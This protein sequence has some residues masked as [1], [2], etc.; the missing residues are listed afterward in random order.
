M[1]CAKGALWIQP[2]RLCA[3]VSHVVVDVCAIVRAQYLLFAQ[4]S[5]WAHN[6]FA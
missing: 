6:I 3:L 1:R 5:A 2:A 4:V